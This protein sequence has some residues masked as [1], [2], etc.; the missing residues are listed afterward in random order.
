M[1][2]LRQDYHR[3]QELETEI[4]VIGPEDPET[5]KEYWN[6]YDFEM[7]G[8]PDPERKVLRLFGQEVNIFKAGRMP[9]LIVIDKRGIVRF[10]HY[11]KQMSDIP[12]NEDILDQIREFNQEN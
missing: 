3:Y 4:L 1:A 8:M 11:G 10:A 5:F 9:A 12:D 7:I 6:S 2:Q